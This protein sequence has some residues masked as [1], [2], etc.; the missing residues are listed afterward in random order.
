MM[1]AIAFVGFYSYGLYLIHQPYVIYAGIRM[2]GYP[3]SEFV[4][5]A[6]A[7]IVV[8]VLGCAY[9]ERRV[10]YL[11]VRVLGPR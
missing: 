10:N 8:F 11:A 2:R 9:I 6:G 4:L 7:T 5:A 3:M 1:T